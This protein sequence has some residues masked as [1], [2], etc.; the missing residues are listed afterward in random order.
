[1]RSA[2]RWNSTAGRRRQLSRTFPSLTRGL[3]RSLGEEVER[4]RRCGA[5]N[6]KIALK[7]RL[8]PNAHS[9]TVLIQQDIGSISLRIDC[10]SS[11]SSEPF[12]KGARS[13]DRGYWLLESEYERRP[14]EQDD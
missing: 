9:L 3:V 5:F 7:W 12:W 11:H 1:M 8:S 10:A 4:C 6:N 13:L 2:I 14:I